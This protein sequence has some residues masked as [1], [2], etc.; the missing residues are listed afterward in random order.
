MGGAVERRTKEV[1][2][3]ADAVMANSSAVAA[4]L[5]GVVTPDKLTVVLNGTTGLGERWILRRTTCPA[6]RSS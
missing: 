5:D 3:A 1:L 4:L 6:S 2:G